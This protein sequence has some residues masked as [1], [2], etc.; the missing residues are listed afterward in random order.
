MNLPMDKPKMP[1]TS[2]VELGKF[3]E[4]ARVAALAIPL[5]Q[6]SSLHEGLRIRCCIE[7]EE[8]YRAA[9]DFNALRLQGPG[10]GECGQRV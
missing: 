4:H 5:I 7:Q 6:I 3:L 9:G 1:H 2:H 10:Q 8:L